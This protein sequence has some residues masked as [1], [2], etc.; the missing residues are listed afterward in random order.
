MKAGQITSFGHNPVQP[1]DLVTR[2]PG[3]GKIISYPNHTDAT[4]GVLGSGV[5]APPLESLRKNPILKLFDLGERYKDDAEVLAALDNIRDRLQNQIGDIVDLSS[6]NL[7]A[8]SRIKDWEDRKI[9]LQSLLTGSQALITPG[10]TRQHPLTRAYLAGVDLTEAIL[11]GADLAVA[12]LT[13]ANLSRA[14]LRRA[15]LSGVNLSG[16]NLTRADLTRADLSVANLTGADLAVANL[17]R[18]DLSIA[19]LRRAILTGADLRR[20]ILSRADLT[21]AY[22][23]GTDLTEADLSGAILTGANLT[24]AFAYIDSTQLTGEKLQEHLTSKFDVT[25]DKDAKF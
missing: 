9:N 7:S 16:V 15:N 14:D 22:L 20:A 17:T 6:L 25:I 19:D 18:A 24:D 12:N 8:L 3:A 2:Q 10:K 1:R 13:R 23:A 21:R 4:S 5:S 11:S